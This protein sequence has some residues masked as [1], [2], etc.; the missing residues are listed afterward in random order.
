MEAT[1]WEEKTAD[2]EN[3]SRRAS[4]RTRLHGLLCKC[5]LEPF[6]IAVFGCPALVITVTGYMYGIGL[7][8]CCL[9]CLNEAPRRQWVGLTLLQCDDS[10]TR[11]HYMICT[12]GRTDYSTRSFVFFLRSLVGFCCCII[13]AQSP[14]Q[15]RY[16]C[17]ILLP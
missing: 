13:S 8:Y 7:L 11:V 1:G 10:G 9:G 2:R 15:V 6:K 17:S 16:I 4:A 3:V 14:L 12:L 5:A